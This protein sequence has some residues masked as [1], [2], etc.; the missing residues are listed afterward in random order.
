MT[1]MKKRIIKKNIYMINNEIRGNKYE[2]QEDK[3]M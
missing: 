1:N 2:N 3:E